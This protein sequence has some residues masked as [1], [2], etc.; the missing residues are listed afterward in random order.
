MAAV[1]SRLDDEPPADPA[2]AE[3]PAAAF[4]VIQRAHAICS[5]PP[6]IDLAAEPHDKLS[7]RREN[8]NLDEQRVQSALTEGATKIL[9]AQIRARALLAAEMKERGDPDLG[10]SETC[11]VELGD[12]ETDEVVKGGKSETCFV[13]ES[14]EFP[15]ICR[16]AD[17]RARAR[18]VPAEIRR[19]RR[20]LDDSVSLERAYAE[21]NSSGR[22]FQRRGCAQ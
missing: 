21:I 16:A 15:A 3:M 4:E 7:S 9:C 22:A 8:W 14:S 10:V 17:A 11:L 19:A 20:L 6:A 12:D 13:F 18:P 2:E 1:A 5:H